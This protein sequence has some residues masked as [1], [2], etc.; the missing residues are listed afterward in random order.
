MT[1]EIQWRNIMR[2]GVFILCLA[3][4]L[5]FAVSGA[6]AADVNDATADS[7][8][9]NIVI[10]ETDMDDNLASGEDEAIAQT[11]DGMISEKDD[12]TFTS[13]QNKVNST[14]SGATITLENDYTYDD[15]FS[16][17]G[18]KIEKSLTING[19]GHTLNGLSKSAIFYISKPYGSNVFVSIDNVTFVNGKYDAVAVHVSA[20]ITNCVFSNNERAIYTADGTINIQNCVF[21]DNSAPE[22]GGAIYGYK[23]DRQIM[24]SDPVVKLKGC[25][26][27]NNRAE[28]NGGA[29][30][31]YQADFYAQ[32]CVFTNNIA[33]WSGGAICCQMFDEGS[34]SIE[35]CIFTNNNAKNG[36]AIYAIFSDGYEGNGAAKSC[37]FDN[38]DD[39]EYG[40][41]AFIR[42]IDCIFKKTVLSS[43]DVATTYDVSKNLVVTLKDS[44]GQALKSEKVT[45]KVGAISKTLTTNGNGQV[46]L[47]V[48]KL[49]PKTYTATISYD[50]NGDHHKS[51]VAVKVTVKKA[52]PKLTAKSKTFK[53]KAKVKRYVIT[54][55][56]NKNKAM[57]K[58]MVTL[59]VKGKTFKA[60]TNAKGK[61]T[62]KIKKLT[63]KGKYEAMVRFAGNNCYNKVT[64]KVKITVK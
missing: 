61:A 1:S 13:L 25:E 53:V 48:S 37:I 40:E 21:K 14:A 55:K 3:V 56:T 57:K 20:N 12:G 58:V 52:T 24:R 47:D 9:A 30:H 60:K 32:D 43:Y 54:L 51:A 34:A 33:S 23:E 7:D 8:N 44:S 10:G 46:S 17:D 31:I 15:G 35:N 26:F 27:T 64:K 39:G 4:C 28:G 16:T 19:N 41:A 6:C 29:I 11:D 62:F 38:N 5:L 18:I 49:A 63:K 45:I 50:G 36:G 42:T 22:S 59:K 2:K